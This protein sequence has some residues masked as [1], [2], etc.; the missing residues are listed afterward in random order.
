MRGCKGACANVWVQGHACARG[1][2]CMSVCKGTCKGHVCMC[3]EGH[4][5]KCVCKGRGVC[6]GMCVCA[7]ARVCEQRT[8]VHGAV[9]VNGHTRVCPARVAQAS[10]REPSHMCVRAQA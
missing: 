1:N 2:V 8:R 5:C 9:S 6:A 4:A 3:V 10:T 7:R